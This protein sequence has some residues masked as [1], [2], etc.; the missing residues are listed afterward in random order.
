MMLLGAARKDRDTVRARHC[1]VRERRFM[2]FMMLLMMVLLVALAM[3]FAVLVL[4]AAMVFLMM[5][6]SLRQYPSMHSGLTICYLGLLLTR[7]L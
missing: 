5:L 7:C 2:A 6:L 1:R 4:L 3:M